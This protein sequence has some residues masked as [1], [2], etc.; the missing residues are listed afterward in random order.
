MNGAV[1][2]SSSQ[3]HSTVETSTTSA[4]LTEAFLASNDVAG[5]RNQMREMGFVLRCLAVLYQ[6][7]QPA[8]QVAEGQRNL[9]SATKHMDIR[10]WK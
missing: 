5:F 2:S 1:I 7:S 4:E 3:K 8:I 10:V 6:D 9:A